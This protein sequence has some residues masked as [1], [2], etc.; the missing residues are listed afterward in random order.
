MVRRKGCTS[1][2]QTSV[3]L[4]TVPKRLN[5]T[6]F[7]IIRLQVSR[8]FARI[9][10]VVEE[11]DTLVFVLIDEVESLTAARKVSGSS[12]TRVNVCAMGSCT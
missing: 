10:E 11:E 1:H 12:H 8:L 3:H 9:T 7:I 5:A 6:T 2:L 4:H